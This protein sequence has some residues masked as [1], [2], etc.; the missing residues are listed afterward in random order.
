MRDSRRWARRRAGAGLSRAEQR[1]ADCQN[2]DHGQNGEKQLS[3]TR[4]CHSNDKH[5][6][7]DKRGLVKENPQRGSPARSEKMYSQTASNVAGS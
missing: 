7:H 4:G 5:C 3:F 2:R 1:Q 6:P